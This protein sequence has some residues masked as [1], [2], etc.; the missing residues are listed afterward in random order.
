MSTTEE[1]LLAQIWARPDDRAALSVYA[2][3]LVEQ[4]DSTRGQYMQLRL[5]EAPS[6]EQVRLR[7][8]LLIQHQ[9]SW[10]GAAR[11]FVRKWAESVTSPGFFAHV[12]CWFRAR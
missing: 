4:G 9:S 6:A 8:A 2:D 11:P 3:W 1:Q 12:T 10:L 5:L 7:D